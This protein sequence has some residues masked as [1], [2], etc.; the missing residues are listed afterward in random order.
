[1]IPPVQLLTTMDF[2]RNLVKAIT[3]VTA[4]NDLSIRNAVKLFVALAIL[5]CIAIGLLGA[6]LGAGT[7]DR[8]RMSIIVALAVGALFAGAVLLLRHISRRIDVLAEEAENLQSSDC[9]LT[10]R[11]PRMSGG[12]GRVTAGLNG[13][14]AQLQALV[15]EV[16]ARGGE[17][18][19]ASRQI[20][21]GSIDLSSRTEQQASTLE[22]TASSMEQ[23]TMSMK[24]VASAT[25]RAS[26]LTAAAA[27]AASRS[28]Q[29]AG[30]AA[31]RIEAANDSARR[32]SSIIG[33]IDSIAF[34]TNILALNAA[35]EAARAGEQGKGFAVVAAEVRALAQRS[36]ASAREIRGLIEDATSRVDE[37]TLL[38]QESEKTMADVEQ[39][40]SE[41]ARVVDE[42]ADAARE[43]AAGID[44]VKGAIVQMEGVTQQNAALVEQASAAA[45]SMRDQ[46]ESLMELVARFKVGSVSVAQDNPRHALSTMRARPATP[47][48]ASRLRQVL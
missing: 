40:I 21:A 28:G 39:V 11:L 33:T 34:Q 46:A 7:A 30:K 48:M 43:Q 12:L 32:I 19:A 37:G 2:P 5:C 26:E 10:R 9:D 38:V 41:A 27:N 23:F 29:V 24:Q 44:Q 47:L 13:F 17:I 15:I 18:A 31:A 36:A 4:M 35:V 22:E 14:V 3:I 42:I 16:T 45:E 20:S 8:T 6:D 1:M 25:R